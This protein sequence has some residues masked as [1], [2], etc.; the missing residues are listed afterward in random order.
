VFFYRIDRTAHTQNLERLRDAGAMAD[1]VAGEA[2][3][4]GESIG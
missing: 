2:Q 1:R 3:A 4:G